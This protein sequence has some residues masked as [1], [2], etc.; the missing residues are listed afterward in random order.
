MTVGTTLSSISAEGNGVTTS[1]AYPFLVPSSSELVVTFTDA[2]SNATILT[3]SAFSVSGVGSATGGT[4]TYP[5]SGGTPIAAGTTLTIARQLPLIQGTSLANQGPTFAAIESALDY[6]TMLVQQIENQAARAIQI[7][8]ADTAFAT[9][10]P[11]AAV[12]AGQYMAFDSEG[13]PIAALS[14]P[15]TTPISTTMQPIVEAAT[16]AEALALLGLGGAFPRTAQNLSTSTYLAAAAN[17]TFYGVTGSGTTQILPAAS[18]SN[19][20]SFGFLTLSDFTLA[21]ADGAILGGGIDA[22]SISVPAGGFIAVQSDGAHWRIF[23]ASPNIFGY[24][25]ESWVGSWVGS[26][27]LATESW[28]ESY[29]SP[30]SS[31]EVAGYRTYPDGTIEQWG[32][33]SAPSGAGPDNTVNYNIAFPWGCFNVVVTLIDNGDANGGI[34]VD[35]TSATGFNVHQDYSGGQSST[36]SIFWRA[37]GK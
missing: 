30:G 35:A 29:T 10:L 12:R 1:F 37:V 34:S 14:A 11:I 16:I 22:T 25:T 26:L 13:N 4:V 8:P 23:S 33:W 7:N 2:D 31:P 24:A 20:V 27:G 32:E 6:V 21:S 36:Y 18:A 28:V 9:P 3:T 15:G 19:D 5:L 17:G